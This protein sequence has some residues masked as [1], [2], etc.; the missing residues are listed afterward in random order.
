VAAGKNKVGMIYNTIKNGGIILNN[1]DMY[2]I[3]MRQL[4]KDLNCDI[5]DL[6]G[7]DNKTVVVTADEPYNFCH[8]VCFRNNLVVSVDEQLKNFIDLFISDKEGF[9]CLEDISLLARELEKYN[10]TIGLY[11]AFVPDI[12]ANR[13]V[14]PDFDVVVYWGD[15]VVK[16]YDDKR[17]GMA[18]SY[19][20]EG[21]KADAVAVAGYINNEIIGVAGAS[22][23][24]DTM[25]QMGYD[26][27]YKHRNKGVAT[28]LGK[29][30]TRL[31][32]DKGIVPYST[33]AWSNI[34]SKNTLIN[35]GY[36]SAWTAIGAD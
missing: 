31:I 13:Q 12:S 17:F 22:K 28:I 4:A 20:T 7:T 26:V 11:E 14:N 33:L 29:I 21:K 6:H 30:I 27:V 34:A 19:T 16:L 10:K 1:K 35:I 18:L 9:R 15:D 36:K 24:Y 25:W 32:I 8:M 3:V 5:S 2:K 23:D